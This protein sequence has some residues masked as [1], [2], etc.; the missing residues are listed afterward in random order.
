MIL[1]GGFKMD[2]PKLNRQRISILVDTSFLDKLD[3][4]AYKNGL[5]RTSAILVLCNLA[6]DG[7]N[8]MQTLSK[9]LS[10]YE[11]KSNEN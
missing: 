11:A 4:Y 6:I 8:T 10:L 2:K 9:M 7:N 3:E 5:S 1:K